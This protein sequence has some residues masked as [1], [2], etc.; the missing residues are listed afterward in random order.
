MDSLPKD[1][2]DELLKEIAKAYKENAY[3]KDSTT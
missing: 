1:P 2:K 3:N